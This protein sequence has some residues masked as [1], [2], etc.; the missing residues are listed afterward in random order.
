VISNSGDRPNLTGS[1]SYPKSVNSW[2][3]GNFSNPVC[4][5]GPDCYGN[6]GFD[7][8]TGPS[9]QNWDLSILKN[10]AFTERFRMEFRVEAFN[11]WNHPQFEANA[12]LGGLGNNFGAANFG[13]I[14]SAYDPRELQLGLKLIF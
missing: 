12:N 8:I 3:T 13:Q 7:A 11:I 4:A 1:I 10:F 5:T 2:F 14:T 6:L 9:R